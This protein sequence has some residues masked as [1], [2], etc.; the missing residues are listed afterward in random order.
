MISLSILR[1]IRSGVAV[2][3]LSIVREIRSGVAASSL[4]ILR[5]IRSGV[6]VISLSMLWAA[7]VSRH[8]GSQHQTGISVNTGLRRLS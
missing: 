5:E 3:S 8:P 4:S 1:E 2:I 6:A 7:S